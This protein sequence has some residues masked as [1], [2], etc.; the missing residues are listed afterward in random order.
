MCRCC[1]FIALIAHDSASLSRSSAVLQSWRICVMFSSHQTWT[2]VFPGEAC[3]LSTT[4]FWRTEMA[5][6]LDNRQRADGM[7]SFAGGHRF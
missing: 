2:S 7:H 4:F 3:R 5:E 1:N 6:H